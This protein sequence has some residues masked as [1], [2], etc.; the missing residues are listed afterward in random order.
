MV[1][2]H[3]LFIYLVV[4]TPLWGKCED[5]T[6][7][8][9]SGNLESSGTPAIS[10]LDCRGQNTSHRGVFYTV[11]KVLKCRCPKWSRMSHLDIC[12]TSY[13]WKKGRVDSLTPNHK[14]S[15]IDPILV[16]AG[17]VRHTVGKLSRRATSSLQTLSQS[18]VR[19]RSYEHPKSQESKS[20]Q[21]RNFTLGVPGQR[22][23]WVWTQWSNTENTIWGKVVASPESRPWWVKWVQGHLWLVPTP[24]RCRMSSNQLMV[25]F[26]CRI[27]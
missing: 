6:H 25:G 7:T 18:E 8:P 1:E 26:G 27:E 12:S 9:K 5:E 15:R 21:F 24:K 2:H 3:G 16:C 19:A 22:A 13:G 20:R 4:A 11:E 23:I 14:K 17:G 10:E